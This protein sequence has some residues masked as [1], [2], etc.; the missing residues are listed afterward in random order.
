[1]MDNKD[2][3]RAMVF[4]ANVAFG[5][6]KSGIGS[7][8]NDKGFLNGCGKGALAGL[9]TS[10]GE[11]T[12]VYNNYPM[13]GAAAKGIH[14]L[15]V[16]M[17]DCVMR[18]EGMFCQYQ[19]ELGPATLTFRD[20]FL[21][22]LSVTM[23]PTIAIGANLFMGNDF[24]WKTSLY[25]LTPVF[26]MSSEQWM[27]NGYVMGYTQSNVITYFPYKS[28]ALRNL[29]LSH[30]FNHVLFWSKLRFSQDLLNW[31]PTEKIHP[32]LEME[33]I[34]NWWNIGQ[35]LGFNLMYLPQTIDNRTHYY[36]LPEWEAYSMERKIGN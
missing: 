30:E 23:L 3:A 5:C 1:M 9:V 36:Q 12:A 4:G 28:Q 27:Q 8:I 15:G 18:G 32:K 17:S 33:K 22:N 24:D 25:N 14:D 29:V 11:W 34:G 10:A 26:V 31:I 21:P 2:A 16:S 35:D 19:T 13:V 20:S 6:L 7:Y